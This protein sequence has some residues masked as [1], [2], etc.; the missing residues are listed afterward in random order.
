MSPK[1]VLP[2][3]SHSP[4]QFVIDDELQKWRLCAGV[5]VLNSK[6]EILVGE[7]LGK[8]G[9][10]Q[11]PQGGVDA[12]RDE[13][14]KDE[15]VAEAAIRE[16]YEEVGLEN[17]RHVILEDLC[18]SSGVSSSLKCRY[19]TAG[20]GS[21][22]E[23]EGF[24]GQELHWTLFRCSDAKLERD[25][26][27]VCCLTGLNDEPQEFSAVRWATIDWVV[28][29]IWKPKAGPY[30]VLQ[31]GLPSKKQ[32]D[33]QCAAID[34][35]G[36]WCRDNDRSI[37][38][39]EGLVSRGLSV[40][41]AREKAAQPYVQ[42]WQR[43]EF[44]KDREWIVSTFGKDGSTLRRETVYPIGDFEEEYE[45]TS[46]IFGDGGVVKRSCLYL[47]E[48]DADLK[49]AHVTVSETP[50][51][52]EESRRYLKSGDLILRRTFFTSLKEQ[53]GAVSTEVFKRS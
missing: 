5:A 2:A 8:A 28:E 38:V 31:K 3:H 16:L 12:A 26:S 48:P 41:D 1:T 19:T 53:K 29:H 32:W 36:R 9:S 25:P 37:D 46:T 51:G 23:Q 33:G 18:T 30:E 34:F 22:L 6:N 13:S 39:V 20:T 42:S 14:G 40:E 10:W 27:L 21:W 49:I 44:E 35:S 24:S 15:T 45:G 7:R 47:A 52:F 11:A 43:L 50:L 17:G 4:S